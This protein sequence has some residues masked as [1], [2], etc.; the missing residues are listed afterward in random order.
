MRHCFQICFKDKGKGKEQILLFRIFTSAMKILI[1]LF[2]LNFIREIASF[3]LDLSSSASIP[4]TA[5]NNEFQIEATVPGGIYTDLMNAGVL[6]SDPYYR[7]NEDNFKW[8]AQTNWTYSTVFKAP[9]ELWAMN[10]IYLNCEGLDT[11]SKVW[12]NGEIIGTSENMFRRY[13]FSIPNLKQNEDNFLEIEF[14]SPIDYA[15]KTFDDQAQD[16]V[17]P[18]ICP[19]PQ[20]DCHA[21]HIR[22]MQSSFS[23]DWG[24][25]FPSMGIWRSISI[26]GINEPRL[27]F[28][29]WN[30]NSCPNENDKCPV[31]IEAIMDLPENG[32][33]FKGVMHVEL[34]SEDGSD[35]LISEDKEVTIERMKNSLSGRVA[36]SYELPYSPNL[37]RL[38]WPNGFWGS[39]NT[40]SQPMYLLNLEFKIQ[41]ERSSKTTKVAF[42]KVE[43][44]EEDLSPHKGRTFKFRVNG[45]DVF[46][47]GSNWI[48]AHVLPEKVT[49]EYIYDLLY[50]AK[51]ANM[52]M[53][54]V[55]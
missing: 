18:P 55:W 24:P 37:I 21:N 29:K 3:E 15:N 32:D 2:L 51:E 25:S 28:V 40:R 16:Y 12:L 53:I 41:G 6:D 47:K 36:I 7:F 14:Q 43:V 1:S 22:K 17:V 27:K 49:P 4:W 13:L 30:S 23:W 9:Y 42:R 19:L 50:S 31:S 52:N 38:W 20:G 34:L 44:I 54:R 5:K 26:I 33:H 35:T 45:F 46:A 11:I 8:V 48:P 10:S 39:D